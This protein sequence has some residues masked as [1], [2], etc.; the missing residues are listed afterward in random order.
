MSHVLQLAVLWLLPYLGPDET[1]LRRRPEEEDWFDSLMDEYTTKAMKWA[2]SDDPGWMLEQVRDRASDRKLRLFA[3]AC[4]RQVWDL[5]LLDATRHAVEVAERLAEGLATG[6]EIL[7][8]GWA[9]RE[10]YLVEDAEV[11]AG[12]ALADLAACQALAPAYDAATAAVNIALWDE[13]AAATGVVVPSTC[14]RVT[15]ADL[16]R[17]VVGNPFVRC[18]VDPRWIAWNGGSV[19]KLAQVIYDERRFEDLPILADALEE[20]G[21]DNGDILS[22]CR[23]PGPHVRGCWVVDL[24][25]AK[26]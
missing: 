13:A 17:D 22:H 4:L 14:G 24:L 1:A 6:G 5:L 21:C 16:L 26:E 7:Q 3:V 2:T 11:A 25:L 23:G 9:A 18:R 10:A 20:A 8:A 12:V 15:R 19:R